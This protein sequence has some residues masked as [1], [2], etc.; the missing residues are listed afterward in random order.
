MR[1]LRAPRIKQVVVTCLNMVEADRPADL[2]G[3]TPDAEEDGRHMRLLNALDGLNQRFGK[4]TVT[5]GPRT[6]MH[7]FVGAKIAFNRIPEQPEF[8]E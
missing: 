1:Q 3:W 8:W 6:K 4:D 7:G 2:F 5:I